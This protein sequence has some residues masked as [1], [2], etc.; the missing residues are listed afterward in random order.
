MLDEVEIHQDFYDLTFL[1]LDHDHIDILI[2][3]NPTSQ[4]SEKCYDVKLPDHANSIIEPLRYKHRNSTE[5]CLFLLHLRGVTHPKPFD[6]KPM[7]N[8]EDVGIQESTFP[9]GFN[10]CLLRKWTDD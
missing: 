2:A 1:E 8:L 7:S 10:S 9:T 3:I 6:P 4:N 5:I